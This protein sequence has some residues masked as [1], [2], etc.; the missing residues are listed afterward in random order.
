MGLFDKLFGSEKR[1]TSYQGPRRISSL[2]NVRG[3]EDYYKNIMDRLQGRGVGFGDDY[4]DIYSSPI[5]KNMRGNFESYQMP[6][7]TSELSATGRRRGSGGFD[8]IR[9]A[10]SEQGLQEGDIFSRLQQRNEDQK[11]SEI[12]DA[13]NRLGIF[14]QNEADLTNQQADSEYGMH[15]DQLSEAD[16]RNQRKAAGLQKLVTTAGSLIAAPFTGGASLAGLTNMSASRS[17]GDP[18]SVNYLNPSS[19]IGY[20]RSGNSLNDRLV[21]RNARL[22]RAA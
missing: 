12:N 16:T 4:A 21:Q 18:Y 22:G 1:D 3:G 20:G 17:G 13:L 10:Y 6:A 15:Q 2:T 11:R 5:I 8:Q 19:N 14:N 7:L 9:R